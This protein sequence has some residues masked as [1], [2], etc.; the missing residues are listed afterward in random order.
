LQFWGDVNG[1]GV[2]DCADLA[3]VKVSFGPKTGQPGFNTQADVN[4]DGV[5][6]IL[7]LS[8]VATQLPA[9]TVCNY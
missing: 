8:I 6:N 7:D 1:D 5:V 4:H 9:G 2:V 3:I